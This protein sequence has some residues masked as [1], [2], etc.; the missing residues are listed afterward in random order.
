MDSPEPVPRIKLDAKIPS[1]FPNPQTPITPP[2]ESR[3]SADS[4]YHHPDLSNEVATLSHKLIRA[5]NHQTDLDDML[6]LTR[7]ELDNARQRNRELEAYVKDNEAKLIK[8]ELLRRSEVEE[9]KLQLMAN[10]AYEQKQRGVMEKDKRGMEQELESLTTALFEEANQ[11]VAA[12]RKEREITDRRNEQLRTQLND[13]ELLLASHQEQLADLKAVMH[14]MSLDREDAEL[15]TGVSTT[16]S[17]PA[18]QTQESLHKIFDALHLSPI[19]PG[20]EDVPP[21]APT[22]FNHLISPVL[23]T[24]VQ[25]YD[26]FNTLLQTSRKSASTS[27][28]TS[29]SYTGLN[30]SALGNIVVREPTQIVSHL[31]STGSTSSLS[32][33]ATFQT[34]PVTPSST[35]SSISSR[36]TPFN[37]ISLKETRFYKRALIEDIE[38]TLRLDAAPG[39]SWLARRT[40][41]N[42]MCEGGLVVEPMS[43]AS[44]F[45]IFA[46][47]LCGEN[48]QDESYA[49]SYRFRTSENENAQ[50]YPL[51]AFCL[52]RLRTSCDFL[53]FLRMLKDG[54]WRAE[55]EEAEVAAWEECVR[56]RE[57]M[58][59]ARIGGGV[60]PAFVRAKE[61]PRSSMEETGPSATTAVRPDRQGGPGSDPSSRFS[62]RPSPTAEQTSSGQDQSSVQEEDS[63]KGADTTIRDDA[64]QTTC[65]EPS[66]NVRDS[67]QGIDSADHLPSDHASLSNGEGL[68]INNVPDLQSN[69]NSRVSI[70]IPGA[71]E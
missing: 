2:D 29:A 15:S 32:T 18:L 53:G 60:V 42:S 5:I 66:N 3:S 62:D 10:L 14:Q 51:C 68:G 70:T 37:G 71:F 26:D 8:G 52:K 30:A 22:S 41:I 17:T 21:A 7:H 23:R 4:P 39:L 43:S 9:Q 20:G 65:M 40:V 58:F 57:R 54:H 48:R 12:A 34:S 27:R 45:N 56:L 47:S 11:M 38:P 33:S 31:P 28:A 19:S 49:R 64:G 13:T 24:D 63:A 69:G 25:A 6:A 1:T 55:D 67:S 59:W 61:S 36:D 35:N 16:P 50:R 46:C 44:Q